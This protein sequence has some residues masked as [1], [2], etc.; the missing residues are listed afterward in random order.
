M[1]QQGLD[2]ELASARGIVDPI[3]QSEIA[4][5]DIDQL[6]VDSQFAAAIEDWSPAAKAT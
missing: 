3:D 6:S 4:V 1:E 5:V 2:R